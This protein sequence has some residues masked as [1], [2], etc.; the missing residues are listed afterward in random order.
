VVVNDLILDADAQKMSKSRGNV[1]DPWEAIG[2]F[3][4]DSIRWYLLAASHPWLP[5]RFDPAG[6]R[7]VQRKL[8][9]TLRNTYRFFALYANLESWQPDA[10]APRVE[11]RPLIDRW[12]LSRLSTLSARVTASM[13]SFDLTPAVRAIGDFVVDDLSNWYVRRSRDRFWGSAES[14][15]ARAAFASLHTALVTVSRLA[16]PFVPFLADW[17]HRAVAAGRS[18]HL[19]AYPE[20]IWARDDALERGMDAVR[21]LAKLGRAAREEVRI[22]VRQPLGVMYAVV[23]TDIEL[24]D[25][26]LEILRDELNVR[27]VVFMRDADELVT[28]SARPN[29]R[30]LGA[31]FGKRTP[32]VAAAIREL[33]TREL[34][35][36]GRGEILDVEVDGERLKLETDD[37]EVVQSARGDYTLAAE[38]G[39][40]A[41]LDP[42]ITPELRAE[43]LARELVN[44]I[45]RLRKEAG[46]DVADRIRLAIGSRGEPHDAALAHRAFVCGETLAVE[47]EVLAGAPAE[48]TYAVVREVDLDGISAVIALE[49]V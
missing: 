42:V 48:G 6:V 9:D 46:L 10:D 40:T 26:L 35:A 45:Q 22:R 30:A 20:P 18:V 41:A 24:G 16:A 49:R 29:F 32:A 21:Q 5:K 31:R 14:V 28:L 38:G 11:E 8:F 25:E 17:L 23:P 47:L 4:A 36:F 44:R 7:E 1:V 3:G 15:D 12:L 13:E 43:G 37:L 19:A 33:G 27:R 2:E 39:Y 34:A